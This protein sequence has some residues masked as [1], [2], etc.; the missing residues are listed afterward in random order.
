MASSEVAQS[1]WSRQKLRLRC[2]ADGLTPSL[3]SFPGRKSCKLQTPNLCLQIVPASQGATPHSPP[4][5]TTAVGINKTSFLHFHLIFSCKVSPTTACV[6]SAVPSAIAEWGHGP[7]HTEHPC[8]CLHHH[9]L[10]SGSNHPEHSPHCAFQSL[11]IKSC[12]DRQQSPQSPIFSQM[13]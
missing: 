11:L 2:K 1:I 4:V 8:H 7:G 9:A 6:P 5:I 12:S 10:K 13:L 3:C